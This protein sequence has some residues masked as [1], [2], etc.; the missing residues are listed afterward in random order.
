[1]KQKM[2][3]T[4]FLFKDKMP[5]VNGAIKVFLDEYHIPT[6]TLDITTCLKN[7]VRVMPQLIISDAKILLENPSERAFLYDSC[8]EQGT[9]F[10]IVDD[11]E[12]VNQLMEITSPAVVAEKFV[13][14]I[15]SKEVAQSVMDILESIRKRSIRK[16]I[17]IVDDSPTFLR[18]ASEWLEEDYNVCV[19]PSAF[20]AIKLINVKRPD[21]ILLDYEMPVCSGAQF[22]EMM[23]VELGNDHPPVMFLTS[24]NDKETVKELLALR[25]QGYMLKTQAKESILSNIR[26]YFEKEI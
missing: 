20:A 16:T 10:I 24:K 9:H 12:L 17:L 25:P 15:N 19:C 18:T 1:M 21:M 14:P 26:M 7:P 22:L 23:N 2:P 5:F 3:Q 13:R 6:D 4:V 11:K 8:I